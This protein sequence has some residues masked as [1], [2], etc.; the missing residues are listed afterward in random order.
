MRPI[1]AVLLVLEFL[2]AVS[3]GGAHTAK[4][5]DRRILSAAAVPS[6]SLLGRQAY[7]SEE[8]GGE[9]EV[10]VLPNAAAV[11][12]LLAGS[13]AAAQPATAGIPEECSAL[14]RQTANCTAFWHCGLEVRSGSRPARPL[15]V[16]KEKRTAHPESDSTARP[17]L[18]AATNPLPAPLS[19]QAGCSD[20]TG[21]LLAPNACALLASGCGSVPLQARRSPSAVKVTSGFP[22]AAPA[23]LP[24]SAALQAAFGEA[25]QGH[26]I[27]GGD[28]HCDGSLLPG[29]CALRSVDDAAALCLAAPTC[30]ALVLYSQ[31]EQA[32]SLARCPGHTPHLLR[33]PLACFRVSHTSASASA[34]PQSKRGRVP[35]L[36]CSGRVLQPSGPPHRLV[37]TP[38]RPGR[39]LRAAGSPQVGGVGQ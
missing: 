33:R 16:W 39:L 35:R 6:G 23:A 21:G 34:L 24:A 11:L 17:A 1:L 10:L 22:V 32:R 15:A 36:L 8:P 20:G 2:E 18:A 31:G 4:P 29:G 13:T 14:C 27:Q 12:P 5:Q 19:L 28:M 30:Q 38:C 26:G 25:I 7:F 3:A 37:L 9:N